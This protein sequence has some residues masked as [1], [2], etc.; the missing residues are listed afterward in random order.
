MMLE[1]LL[2]F[3][4]CFRSVGNRILPVFSADSDVAL[5]ALHHLGF[6][7]SRVTGFAT[8]HRQK[9]QQNGC[10]PHGLHDRLSFPVLTVVMRASPSPLACLIEAF[11]D[12]GVT[13]NLKYFSADVTVQI[14]SACDTGSNIC[15]SGWLRSSSDC[16][17]GRSPELSASV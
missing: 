2:A 10:R 1:V 6:D 9:S 7:F 3:L 4:G 15:L 12:A 5:D 8:S 13:S 17:R 14:P 16:C 11:V